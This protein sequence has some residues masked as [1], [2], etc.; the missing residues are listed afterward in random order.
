MFLFLRQPH[1]VA[2]ADLEPTFSVRQA[3]NLQSCLSSWDS[4]PEPDRPSP[5]T[6]LGE[7]LYCIYKLTTV[8][9]IPTKFT[10]PEEIPNTPTATRRVITQLPALFYVPLSLFPKVPSLT[11]NYLSAFCCCSGPDVSRVLESPG[12]SVLVAKLQCS[13]EN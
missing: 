13:Q 2:Q 12:V 11:F 8:Y 4:K 10:T 7:R 6:A 5:L 3:C 1:L 9:F